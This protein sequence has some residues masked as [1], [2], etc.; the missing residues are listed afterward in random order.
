VALLPGQ[1]HKKRKIDKKGYFILGAVLVL[2]SVLGIIFIT[3][4][5][6]GPLNQFIRLFGLWGFTS[7]SIAAMMSPFLREISRYFGRPFIRIHHIFAYTGLGLITVH[8]ILNAVQAKSFSV[9]IPVFSSWSGFWIYA[10]R[11]ALILIYIALL[12]VLIRSKLRPWRILH[13]TVYLVLIMG[14]V[15]GMLIG[16]DLDNTAVMVVFAILIALVFSSFVIKRIRL[17]KRKKK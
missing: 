13:M 16:T 1:K 7:I 15:H 5:A 11:M 8:P 6:I 9:F 17:S 14:F 4:P 12:A 10:G 2:Y 3:G